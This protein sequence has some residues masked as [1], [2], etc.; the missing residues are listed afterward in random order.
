MASLGQRVSVPVGWLQL[1]GQISICAS[2]L[3]V[4]SVY[5]QRSPCAGNT[6][7]NLNMSCHRVRLLY[8]NRLLLFIL[9]LLE[10]S[11]FL[12]QT[13]ALL[14]V[15]VG[16]LAVA[17]N[18]HGVSLLNKLRHFLFLFTAIV[19]VNGLELN[20]LH[21]YYVI[22]KI[23]QNVNIKEFLIKKSNQFPDFFIG[24]L[25]TPPCTYLY[26]P[27]L[28]SFSFLC[29]FSSRFD[30]WR[31]KFLIFCIFNVCIILIYWDHPYV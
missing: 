25:H 6:R 19:V 11:M 4:A 23:R 18:M 2:D 5:R 7:R 14:P 12:R 8:L 24:L 15:K 27:N 21:E 3:L 9:L 26:E 29:I 17:Y 31:V 20:L 1:G 10:I 28:S 13:R 16:R 30:A 22:I